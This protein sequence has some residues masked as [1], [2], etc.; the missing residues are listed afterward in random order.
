MGYIY[1]VSK[2]PGHEVIYVTMRCENHE[3]VPV[4]ADLEGKVDRIIFTNRLAKI[5]EVR[6]QLGRNPQN[7]IDDN[8]AWL[9]DDAI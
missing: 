4:V 7:W 6:K 9:F 3:S 8:P 2:S 1:R 5:T